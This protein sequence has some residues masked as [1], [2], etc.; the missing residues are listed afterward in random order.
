KRERKEIQRAR[1]K[2]ERLPKKIL[3]GVLSAILILIIAVVAYAGI[4]VF[5]IV[6]NLPKHD[7]ATIQDDLKSVSTIY[8]DQG[9]EMQDIYLG[10]N[11]RMIVNYNDIPTNLV[12]AAVSIEDKTFWTNNGFNFTRIVGAVWESIR[13]GGD[14]SGTSTITQQLARNIWLTSTRSDY[15]LT[16]KIQ[17]AW[18]A[19]ELSQSLSK[20]QIMTAY[21]NMISLGNHSY[22]VAAAAKSY[23]DKDLKD[24]DLLECAALAAL[25]QSPSKYSLITTV[26]V[27]GASPTDPN[28]LLTTNQYMFLYNDAAVPR[29]HLVLDEMLAQGYITKAEHDAAYADNIRNHLH[30]QPL[31]TDSISSFFTDYMVQNVAQNLQAAYP[32][33]FATY[34]DALQ[35]VYTGGYQI[36][37]TYDPNMQ[38]IVAE[39]FNDPS[40]YPTAYLPKDRKGNV[41][42]DA[43]AITLYQYSNLFEDRSDGPWFT[44]QPNE[45]QMFS[46][47]GMEI[48]KGNRLNFYNTTNPDGSTEVAVEFPNFYSYQDKDI[49]ITQG[50]ILTI[51][52]KYKSLDTQGNLILSPAFFSSKD[53]IF[54]QDADG[55]YEI[56]PTHFTLRQAII[57][58]QG[59]MVIIDHTNG[60][61]K[62][63]I[64]GRNIQGQMQF[65]RA[66]TERQPGSTMKPIGTYGPAIEM[67][68]EHIPVQ[69]NSV[70]FVDN[71]GKTF[72]DYWTPVSII[73]DTSMQYQGRAWPHD[74]YGTPKGPQTMRQAIQQSE[75]IPAVKVQLA[76]GV[77]RSV[78]FLKKLGIT[79][80]VTTGAVNDLNPASLALG[81][82]THG[83]S[84]LEMASAYGT[85]ANQGVHE[86]VITYTKVTDREGNIVLDGTT[87]STKVMDPGAAFIVNDML[88]STVQNGI[89]YTAQV[90]GVPVAGKTGTSSENYDAWFVGNTP[91]YSAAVWIG[92]DQQIKMSQN[93][94]ASARMFSKIM[95]RIYDGRDAG[96]FP[97]KP[98]DVV[99]ASVGGYTDYFIAGTVPKTLNYG[100][101]SFL[102]DADSGMLATP[103]SVHTFTQYYS[104]TPGDNITSADGSSMPSIDIAP[105]WYSPINNQDTSHYPTGPGDATAPDYAPPDFS[106]DPNASP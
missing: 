36:Y 99:R 8:D 11:Y 32:N 50:G 30:P 42:N 101:R 4:Y 46:D 5:N 67:S 66:L 102:I 62:A 13:G 90:K 65:N 104:L 29:I 20:Q 15:S 1:R 37:S 61:L 87:K 69:G 95:T 94:A 81:G 17:E 57:Q 44:L 6:H 106:N 28:L 41:I 72:G 75:N 40:N 56:G 21:L 51:P 105:R 12:N 100:G 78:A 3:K 19:R 55:N 27:G 23:F 16:R 7:P 26:P 79:S 39:A 38:E 88:H 58:P 10:D 91:Q 63:M 43:G 2:K 48:F 52:A 31:Q 73:M 34:D 84:P 77:E 9:N 93:S 96:E 64:G 92:L 98:D 35:A 47:G 59:A 97:A 68:A 89:A 60:Q 22:G 80:L 85:F 76:V 103:W 18:Y 25:P 71:D 54:T 86:D 53:N 33:D 70:T 82:L 45:Y 83:V 24:L 49:Y 74:W 14:I